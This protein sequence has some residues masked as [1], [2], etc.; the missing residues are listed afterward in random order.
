MM[1]I[2]IYIQHMLHQDIEVEYSNESLLRT[3]YHEYNYI[4]HSWKLN[5]GRSYK[6]SALLVVALL[7]IKLGLNDLNKKL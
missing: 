6:N 5:R 3:T 7:A 4:R 2:N 1:N